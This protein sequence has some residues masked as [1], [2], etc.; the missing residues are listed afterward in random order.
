MSDTREKAFSKVEEELEGIESA[1]EANQ[2]RKKRSKK[3][4]SSKGTSAPKGTSRS[5][6]ER[7]ELEAARK[8]RVGIE[9]AAKQC[10]V[11][12]RSLR[13]YLRSINFEKIG[14]GYYFSKED[15]RSIKSALEER[16]AETKVKRATALKKAQA[17]KKEKGG[18]GK[19]KSRKK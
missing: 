1:P 11:M 12:P 19:K 4:K 3:G 18:K 14:G 15:I 16:K 2:P 5:K 13:R 7:E 17:A 8:G 9:E 6:A 10:G